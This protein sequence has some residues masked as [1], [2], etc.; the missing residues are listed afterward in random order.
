[1]RGNPEAGELVHTNDIYRLCKK[2]FPSCVGE[3]KESC[4][5]SSEAETA[6]SGREEEGPDGHFESAISSWPGGHFERC[7][8]FLQRKHGLMQF[9]HGFMK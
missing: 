2:N 3:D 7:L 8:L 5:R 6:Y 1:M 4:D 9:D